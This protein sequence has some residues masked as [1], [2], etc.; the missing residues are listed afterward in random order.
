MWE[1]LKVFFS[2]SLSLFLSKSKL[3]IFNG[4]ESLLSFRVL[5]RSNR[6]L[7]FLSSCFRRLW[8]VVDFCIFHVTISYLLRIL[9]CTHALSLSFVP[10]FRSMIPMTATPPLLY[11]DPH[12]ERDEMQGRVW[13]IQ[14]LLFFFQA[15]LR[16]I[17]SSPVSFASEI[18][19]SSAP[20]VMEARTAE[21]S[22]ST[23]YG[24]RYSSLFR[25]LQEKEKKR[26]K[27]WILR[28]R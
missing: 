12:C 10:V 17:S 24:N 16:P 21:R 5:F 19:F 4:S 8:Q 13:N 3:L 23:L 9:S 1:S 28:L 25:I 2:L 27:S 11:I 14:K 18:A 20:C 15:S 7:S 22:C 6:I 26:K